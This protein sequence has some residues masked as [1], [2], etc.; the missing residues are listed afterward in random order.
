MNKDI[1]PILITG[2]AGFIGAALSIK[3]LEKGEY[4]IGIDNL[5][6]YYDPSLKQKRLEN[7]ISASNS[8]GGHWEF[9]K[10][11]IENYDELKKIFETKRPKVVVNLA[12]QAGVRYSIENPLA[13]LQSNLVGFGNIL[14][15]CRNFTVDNLIYASSSSVYGGNRNLPYSELQSVNHPVSLYA[16]TKKSNELMAHSYSHLYGIPSTGLRFFTVYGPWGRPDM[17]PMIFAKSILS[18]KPI[19]VFN[20]GKMRRD[21]TYID[22]I[23]EGI[24]GCCYKPASANLTFDKFNPEQSSSFAP[25]RIFNIGNN[26]PVE[27]LKFIELLEESLGIKAIMEMEEMQPGDVIETAADTSKLESWVQFNSKTSIEKGIKQFT[28]WFIEFNK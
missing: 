14:E 11:S 25:Y 10:L 28:K 24:I 19:K 3:L 6:N 17:A 8:F 15:V 1:S 2:A 23:V 26:K 22:D 9:H 12:A 21:F 4:V 5:N 27:L 13:Y 16:A 7:I 18:K 20:F